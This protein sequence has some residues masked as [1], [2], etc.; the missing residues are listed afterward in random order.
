MY[1]CDDVASLAY[2]RPSPSA[3]GRTPSLP[4][5]STTGDEA[6][7]RLMSALR[8]PGSLC[9]RTYDNPCSHNP[10]LPADKTLIM[11]QVPHKQQLPD[12]RCFLQ[13]AVSQHGPRGVA[14]STARR[15]VRGC[16]PERH[17]GAV[18]AH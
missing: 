13:S 15:A 18:V 1:R 16:L 5:L 2:T 14:D 9:T 4:S 3:V 6:V 11:S 10:S 12:C 8:V 17:S 7:V